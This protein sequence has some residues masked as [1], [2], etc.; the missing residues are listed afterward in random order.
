MLTAAP[1]WSAKETGRW[2][3]RG[4]W[5]AV[6]CLLCPFSSKGQAADSSVRTNQRK[7]HATLAATI[8]SLGGQA[9]LD[10][11]NSRCQV[12]IASFFQGEPTGE[13][14]EA[15]VTSVFP[16][17]ERIDTAKGRVVQ[18]FSGT[19]GWEITYKG[20]KE[21]QAEKLDEYLRWRNHSLATV[22]R[23]WY[24]DPA[25]LLI[26][27]GPSQVE[28]REAEKI[29]LMHSAGNGMANDAV[30]LEVDAENHLPLRLS[31]SWRDPRFHDTNLDAVEFDNFHRIDGIAVPFTVTETHN[32][33]VVRQSYILRAQHNV[34]V[35]DDFFNPQFAAVHLK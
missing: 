19:R 20:V 28:R 2:R 25:T 6:I 26:D 22:L 30:T 21:L 16:D 10:V 7:A 23:E 27:R 35:P 18:I 31:F 14:V 3:L 34:A 9:W 4:A 11:R 8:Q 5:L 32:G 17:K 33:E 15:T 24:R 1:C 12:H 29:T 13:V